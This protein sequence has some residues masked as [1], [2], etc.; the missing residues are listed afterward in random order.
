[1]LLFVIRLFANSLMQYK[2]VVGEF[3]LPFQ[4]Q[5]SNY[6][7]TTLK[8]NKT[9]WR[10]P[11]CYILSGQAS[12]IGH[13]KR[14]TRIGLNCGLTLNM[15]LFISTKRTISVGTATQLVILPPHIPRI[16]QRGGILLLHYSMIWVTRFAIFDHTW[17]RTDI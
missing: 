8:I 4:T 11:F 13:S 3:L 15:H 1:M 2:N 17:V 5:L 10:L 12:W 9:F 6:D 16:G 7:T 14:R